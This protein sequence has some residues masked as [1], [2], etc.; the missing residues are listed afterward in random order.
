MLNRYEIAGLKL[1]FLSIKRSLNVLNMFSL[2]LNLTG[3]RIHNEFPI[4]RVE[5]PVN[6]WGHHPVGVIEACIGWHE[7]IRPVVIEIKM[8]VDVSP[9]GLASEVKLELAPPLTDPAII[10]GFHLLQVF[11]R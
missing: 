1:E 2:K 10:L 4:N 8:N 7:S 3:I 6:P 9:Q 11:S 5:I